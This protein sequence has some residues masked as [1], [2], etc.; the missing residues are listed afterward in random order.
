MLCVAG[1]TAA[2]LQ[3]EPRTLVPDDYFQFLDVTEPQV[4]PDGSVVAYVVTSNDRTSDA[5]KSAVWLVNWDGSDARPL[6]QCESVSHAAFSPD[7]RYLAFL[8]SRPADSTPQVWVLDRHGGDAR[9]LTYSS[10]EISSFAWSPD[11]KRLLVV[12]SKTG[13][14]GAKAP[15]P[16]VIDGYRFK[17][18]EEGYLTID[19]HKHIQVI[20]A[21]SGAETPVTSAPEF[22]DDYAAWSPD[23]K[24]I[25]YVSNHDKDA[26]RTG[27]DEIYLIEP[28][29]EAVPRKLASVY[30]PN[31]QHIAFSPDGR[32]VQAME[33]LEPKYFAYM[34][35]RLVII[36]VANGHV[37]A[38][39]DD[40]DQ[41]VSS[42]AFSA[43]GSSIDF[44]VEDHGAAYLAR[45]MLAAGKTERIGP[46]GVTILK[47]SSAGG[48][49]AV[50]GTTDTQPPEVFALEGGAL[51]PLTTHNQGLMAGLVLGAVEDIRFKSRDGT[52][53]EGQ[54]VKPPHYVAGRRYPA[55]VWMHGGP[56]GQDQHE[57]IAE[58]YSPSLERQMLAA[59]GYLAIAV[60]YRGSTGRGRKFQQSIFADWGHKEVEDVLA[61]VDYAVAKGLA[62]PNKL[63]IGG[64]SYGGLLTDYTIA[65]DTRFKAA[66]SGAGSGNQIGVYGVDEYALQYNAELGPPWK[67]TALYVKLSYPFFHADRIR[68]PTLFIGGDK[69]FNV[70]IAGGEQMYQ[71]LRTLGIASQLV[72]YPGEFH[73]LTRPSFLKD[74]AERYAAWFARYLEGAPPAH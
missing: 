11:G 50:L 44:I 19:S 1:F 72:I 30:A 35:D 5:A 24:F 25:A 56:N 17:L 23:G 2:T 10:G 22:N 33:G 47:I 37:Q 31:N 48:H 64:W 43:D 54:M 73:V 51:R 26:E 70:P 62:D 60:N 46:P 18:D 59:R 49:T 61:A 52:D 69:D 29:A 45:R 8:S 53:I 66:V 21:A 14:A 74:R 12:A 20:D 4:S 16:I 71:A 36:S 3:A 38:L 67:N 41:Q 68:T 58:G 65:S 28:K 13:P 32:Y 39:S 9:Q 7:G 34:P 42:P 6:A 57:L 27:V 55:V 15:K 40:L 63:G